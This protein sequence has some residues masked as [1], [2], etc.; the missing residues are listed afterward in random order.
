MYTPYMIPGTE[1]G[2]AMPNALDMKTRHLLQEMKSVEEYHKKYRLISYVREPKER[3]KEK[4]RSR[5]L[6][7]DH[8]KDRSPRWISGSPRMLLALVRE[9]ESRRGEILN[10]FADI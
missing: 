1:I 9:F 4:R 6:P 5:S 7:T 3:K 8:T 10:S 2:N